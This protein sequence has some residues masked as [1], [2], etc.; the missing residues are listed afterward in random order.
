MG[1]FSAEK[2]KWRGSMKVFWHFKEGNV[3]H[4]SRVKKRELIMQQGRGRL[5]PQTGPAGP[6]T[7]GAGDFGIMVLKLSPSS[8]VRGKLPGR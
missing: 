1:V 5:D 4:S 6:G 3:L 7:F 2:G 8:P